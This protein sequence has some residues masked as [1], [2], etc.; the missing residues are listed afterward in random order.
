[1]SGQA[2]REKNAEVVLRPGRPE[3]AAACGKICY[4]AFK[5][6]SEQ[7]GFSPDIPSVD[8]AVGLMTMMLA[9]PH[10]YSVIAES[11]GRILGSNF[12]LEDNV[13]GIGPITVDPAAQNTAIGKRLMIDAIN[14]ARTKGF[15][16]IR[17]VQAAFHTRS[18]ALYAKLGFVV[19]ETLAN[20]QGAPLDEK[21]PGYDV[22]PATAEDVEACRTLCFHVHGHSRPLDFE[23]GMRHGT[24]AAV[25]RNGRITGYT[26]GVGFFGHSVGE[27]NDDLKALIAAAPSFAGPGFLLPMRNA[28]L[29]RWCLEKKLRVVQ[30]MTLMTVGLYN[31]PAGAFLPSIL[32]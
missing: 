15:P 6:I 11:G 5:T 17:L 13:A 3:D 8:M 4:E 18:L 10:V 9:N 27:T 7:H 14:R 23:A 22:R 32:Y 2:A 30:P 19:R 31:E 21:I 28:E 24:A 1:M 25:V 12:M 16:G 26:S 20:M 29:F